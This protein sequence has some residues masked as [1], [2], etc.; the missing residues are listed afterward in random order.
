MQIIRLY[1]LI[2]F[3]STLFIIMAC[4]SSSSDEE[5]AQVNPHERSEAVYQEACASCHGIELA[6][7]ADRKWEY[8]SE[9]DSIIEVIT[10]GIPDEEMPGYDSVY[11]AGT[12]D[13]LAAYILTI[14]E[15]VDSYQ[16][17][18]ETDTSGTFTAGAYDLLLDT[19]ITDMKSPWGMA[20]LPGGDLL[21][22]DKS[23]KLYRVAADGTQSEI[24]G[25]PEVLYEGQ[26][27]LFEVLLH[28]EFEENHWVY[29]SYSISK[30]EGEEVLA[31]LAVNR[32][33]LE[34]DRLTNSEMIFEATPYFATRHHYGGRMEFAPDGTIY[35]SAGERGKRD[36]NPQA[37]DRYPG[38]IHRINDDGSIP[39]DNPFV[40]Q[41]DVVASI[42]SYGHRN[43][44]G[45]T[46]HPTTGAVW[47]HEHGPR[48]GDEINIP[49]K[50]LNYGWPVVTHGINY[51]GTAMTDMVEKEGMEDPMHYWVPS[52]APSGMAF[53][54][55]DGY[56]EWEGNLLVGSLKY[57]FLDRI[58]LDG[59]KV[60]EEESLL[61]KI[62]RV[63]SVEMGPDGYIYVGVEGSPGFVARLIPM[64]N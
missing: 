15:K 41:K 60:V 57:Q 14:K 30:K 33:V 49:K 47:T 5:M 34:G 37:L 40:N 18:G 10:H 58:V 24:Q 38:K 39:Q 52:I 26:G 4:E 13:S 56:P 19:V 12:I 43:P 64:D 1:F 8:G 9:K 21:V 6:A 16:F 22:T 59:E 62:G 63:R 7:F 28:P 48:G 46:I 55:G 17:E 31:S 11:S 50:G 54:T 23:G 42:F 2:L 35:L 45:M 51:S 25:L 44:Q 29:L 61:K 20:F 32:A 36:E 53:I 3:G 27:G